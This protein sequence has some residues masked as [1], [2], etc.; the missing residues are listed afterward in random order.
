MVQ[1]RF[2]ETSNTESLCEVSSRRGGW[3]RRAARP[4]LGQASLGEA[5]EGHPGTRTPRLTLEGLHGQLVWGLR[6]FRAARVSGHRQASWLEE[7]PDFRV[8]LGVADPPESAQVDRAPSS[9]SPGVVAGARRPCTLMAWAPT[10]QGLPR[11]NTEGT[12]RHCALTSPSP[13]TGWG[14][15][16]GK[17]CCSGASLRVTF[18][19]DATRDSDAAELRPLT[20]RVAQNRAWSQLTA[21]SRDPLLTHPGRLDPSQEAGQM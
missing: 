7:V 13:E 16:P 19:V 2:L 12:V 3:D 18:G 20:L 8:L 17:C 15:C 5:G 9:Q 1:P 14:Q 10:F 6:G 4:S 11:V 21:S